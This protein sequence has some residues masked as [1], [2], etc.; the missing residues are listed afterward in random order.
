MK[1]YEMRL[2][3]LRNLAQ[4]LQNKDLVNEIEKFYLKWMDTYTLIS[5]LIF[6]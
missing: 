3:E 5:K 1:S 2:N 4:Q 6:S